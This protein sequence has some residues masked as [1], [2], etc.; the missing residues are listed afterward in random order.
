MN[1]AHRPFSAEIFG[2]PSA[3]ASRGLHL[4]GR[5]HTKKLETVTYEGAGSV[6]SLPWEGLYQDVSPTSPASRDTGARPD[7]PL[8]QFL[9]NLMYG[10]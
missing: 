9:C 5:G 10:E 8:G 3:P 1:I 2:D 4:W 6:V 7:A